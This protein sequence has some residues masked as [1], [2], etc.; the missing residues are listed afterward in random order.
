VSGLVFSSFETAKGM[1]AA[2]IHSFFPPSFVLFS[3]SFRTGRLQLLE[4]QVLI[5]NRGKIHLL[6]TNQTAST[7][8][9]MRISS[10]VFASLFPNI[11]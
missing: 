2:A 4:S 9:M 1:R 3:L 8:R 11:H 6:S 7:A 5:P 10:I